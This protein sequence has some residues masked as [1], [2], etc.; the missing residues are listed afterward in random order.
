MRRRRILLIFIVMGLVLFTAALCSRRP[1]PHPGVL[2]VPSSELMMWAGIILAFCAA[3]AWTSFE[4]VSITSR[5]WRL[6][7]LLFLFWSG[8]IVLEKLSPWGRA[9]ITLAPLEGVSTIPP[10]YVLIFIV[11]LVAGAGVLLLLKSLIY[12]QQTRSTS[13]NFMLM[14]F[15]MLL[16]AVHVLQQEPIGIGRFRG[17]EDQ[18]QSTPEILLFSGFMLFVVINGFRCKWIHY[19]T[20]G[21]KITVFFIGLILNA[22]AHGVII[23]TS[24]VIPLVSTV[25]ASFLRDTQVF[26]AIYMSMALL[27]ILFQLPSAGLMDRRMRDIHFLQGLGATLGAVMHRE[28]LIEKATELGR[29]VIGA[30]GVWVELTAGEGFHLAGVNGLKNELITRIPESLCEKLRAMARTHEHVYLVNDVPRER[31]ISGLRR[32]FRKTGAIMVAS[33]RF[34]GREVGML[35]ATSFNRFA[36]VEESRGLFK[37]FADQLGVALENMRLMKVTIDQKVYKE[38]LRV[39]HDAQMRLLPQHLPGLDTAKIS[40]F[41]ETAN[42]IGGDFYE[43]IPVGDDRVDIIVADVSGKGAAAA[44]YMAEL[45]GVVQAAARHYNC[46][47]EIL[48]EINQFVRKHF[49]ADTFV[50][51]IYGIYYHTL[52]TLELARA[53]HT[54]MALVRHRKVTWYEPEGLGLGLATKDCFE[55]TIN[56]EHLSLQP[57][58]S[59]FFMTDGL[60]EARDQHEEEFG[61]IRLTE[62][63][64][65]Q[66]LCDAAAMI[67]DVK[68]AMEAFS[69]GSTRHD[70]VTMVALTLN[71]E[72]ELNGVEGESQ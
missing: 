15:F 67:D 32:H 49:E 1:I 24:P 16:R 37:A 48:T 44:F 23:D 68:Q 64:E 52:N 25:A 35:Y 10:V 42:E 50:T 40:A 38:E 21:Q 17:W 54:P 63:L 46:P 51:M 29:R 47:K 39:A 22:M 57:C 2:H 14:M 41:C 34:K 60:I 20:R 31:R 66:D 62:I 4:E 30:D 12:V 13:T 36:F 3:S 9:R 28:E 43:F 71:K 33:I 26:V 65:S 19:L 27:G 18:I 72:A 69:G 56:K 5:L 53:G 45:K 58:D 7:P 8:V 55:R 59:L 70:D 11:A 6:V 61:E